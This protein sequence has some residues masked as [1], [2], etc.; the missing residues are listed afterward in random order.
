MPFLK[1]KDNTGHSSSL[2]NAPHPPGASLEEPYLSP[3]RK[4]PCY[5][6]EGSNIHPENG[7]SLPVSDRSS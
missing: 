3:T 4:T 7:F 6:R 2:N 1:T 5:A